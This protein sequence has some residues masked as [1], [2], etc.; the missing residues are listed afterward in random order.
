MKSVLITGASRGI[1]REFARQYAAHGW[2]VYA[3]CR[4]PEEGSG[5]LALDITDES[6]IERLAADVESLDLLIHN[7]GIFA[8]GEEGLE[9]IDDRKMTEVFRVNVIGPLL[10]TKYLLPKLNRGGCVAALTSGAG[11]L[12]EELREPGGAYS[13]GASKAA[14]ARA[15][16]SL[17]ADLHP[18]GIT[19]VGLNPGY[20]RTDMT[21]GEHSP[22]PL[23]AAESVAGMITVLDRIAHEQT[24]R[25]FDYDGREAPWFV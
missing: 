12:R 21:G 6:Q 1:G 13:Y 23:S 25:F 24:G 9:K 2:R 22:A 18:R 4:K 8:A 14:L 20:V 17:A 7:A 15:L 11:L 10:L 3:A 16:Q 19:V 5:C